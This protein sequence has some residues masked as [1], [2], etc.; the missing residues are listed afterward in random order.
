LLVPLLFVVLFF[1]SAAIMGIYDGSIRQAG[2]VTPS[3]EPAVPPK[4]AQTT[5]QALGFKDGNGQRGLFVAIREK[6][7]NF[8]GRQ[9]LVLCPADG[10]GEIVALVNGEYVAVNGAARGR[11]VSKTFWAV[12]GQQLILIS[13]SGFPNDVPKRL[14]LLARHMNAIIE[15]GVEMCPLA[16]PAADSAWKS[17]G[18]AVGNYEANAR[19]LG[20]SIP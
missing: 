11:A 7:Q 10:T 6:Q 3:S 9:V 16:S 2:P 17:L 8:E 15:T 18:S 12:Q 1:G 4:V 5:V 13:D 19:S 14:A 20:I